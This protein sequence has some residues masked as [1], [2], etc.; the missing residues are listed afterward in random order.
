MVQ[1]NISNS[2]EFC[3]C[4]LLQTTLMSTGA[5]AC[6]AGVVVCTACG[7]ACTMHV[8]LLKVA[9]GGRDHGYYCQGYMYSQF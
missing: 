5:V 6:T 7:V 4:K 3:E 9:C 2:G 1:L 8:P